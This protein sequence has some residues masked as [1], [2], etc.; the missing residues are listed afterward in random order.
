MTVQ[1]QE[2]VARRHVDCAFLPELRQRGYGTS[3]NFERRLQGVERVIRA[4]RQHLDQPM[5]NKVMSSIACFSPYHFN[6]M[7]RNLTGIPPIQFHHALRLQRAKQLLATTDLCVT[8]ICF[9]VG[10]NSLGTF[11]TRFHELVGL[12]PTSFRRFS[13]QVASVDMREFKSWLLGHCDRINE[14]NLIVGNISHIGTFDGVVFLGLF[15]R[16]IPE[17]QPLACSL[18]FNDDTY[19]I[20][21]P[22]KGQYSVFAVA[23]PWATSGAQ[24]LT[25]ESISRGKTDV[26]ACEGGKSFCDTD[27]ALS[28]PSI[29]D[30]PILTVIPLLI[31]RLLVRS[32]TAFAP[33]RRNTEA[34]H[35]VS[36]PVVL[37]RA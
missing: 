13:Q 23:V 16:G 5:T 30:P 8:E 36:N 4:M 7:F 28:P 27:L 31:R 22:E 34:A 32:E 24:L 19:S 11:V 15:R 17:G 12:S 29:L 35:L 9:E 25:L 6:R 10:Y 3:K 37:N 33:V 1:P 20:A 21:A 14:G 18:A 26:A 2:E